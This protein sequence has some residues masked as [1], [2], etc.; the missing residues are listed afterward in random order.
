M[1]SNRRALLKISSLLMTRALLPPLPPLDRY[2]DGLPDSPRVTRPIIAFARAI[3]YGVAV[4]QEPNLNAKMVG[5]LMPDTVLPIY[6]ELVTDSGNWHNKLWYEV[7]G[8]YVHSA[9]IQPVPWQLNE[10]LTDAGENG[11]W[12][13]VTVPYTDAR[14][15]PSLN[16]PRTKYRYYGSTVYKVITVVKSTGAPGA[17]DTPDAASADLW[18]QIEDEMK[19][20]L[21]F[22]P[23]KHLRPISQAEFTPLSPDVDP[24]DKK[25]VVNL[26]EQRVHAYEKDKEVFTTRTATGAVFKDLGDKGDFQ[27]PTGTFHVYRKT[28]TQHMYGGAAG[29][30]DYF[31]LPGIPWVSYFITTG[32]AFH[33][34]YWHNDYGVQRSHGCV[35]VTSASAKWIWRW[36]MPPNDLLERYSMTKS[37]GD[38]TKVIVNSL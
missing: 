12:A 10:P 30:S 13:E 20:G 24:A 35:N 15:G 29:D 8:G 11:F 5:T 2:A 33:G 28:P 3:N 6:A 7:Q 9:L 38:G 4:R 34:T 25:L 31:D 18:Y 26:R 36:T 27:T 23:G 37:M 21:Y 17:P 32:I 1:K 14:F 22:V 19:P 16:A